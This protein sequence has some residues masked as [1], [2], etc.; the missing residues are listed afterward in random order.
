[1]H[2]INVLAAKVNVD[3]QRCQRETE[4]QQFGPVRAGGEEHVDHGVVGIRLGLVETNGERVH[5]L[6]VRGESVQEPGIMQN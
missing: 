4:R 5:G 1:M 6:E 2:E 3:E